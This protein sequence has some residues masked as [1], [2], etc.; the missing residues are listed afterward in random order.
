[1]VDMIISLRICK[2]E[3]LVLDT[4][5]PIDDTKFREDHSKIKVVM[6]NCMDVFWN[7]PHLKKDELEEV[8]VMGVQITGMC[9]NTFYLFSTV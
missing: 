2:I 1:M 9:K 8:F 6:K 5:G 3:L 7:K 4:E